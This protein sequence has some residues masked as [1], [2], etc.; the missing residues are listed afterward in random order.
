[1]SDGYFTINAAPPFSASGLVT[2]SGLGLSGVN[3]TFSRVSG[4]GAVPADVVTDGGGNWSQTG[5]QAGT[6]YQVTPAL[7]GYSFS[8][9]SLSFSTNAVGLNFTGTQA[10]QAGITVTSPNVALVWKAG[11]TQ[12]IRWT[13]TGNP[14]SYVRIELL[15][16]DVLSSTISSQTS[17]VK[18]SY[19]WK[20]QR[21]QTAGTDYKIRITSISNPAVTDSS[22]VNFTITSAR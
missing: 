19:N 11:S 13:Y 14:G 8:P 4:T 22:D 20:I 10:A 6:T 9:S 17:T 12:T 7:S 18:G 1:M 21:K 16:N 3:M 2:S 15:K 5:F